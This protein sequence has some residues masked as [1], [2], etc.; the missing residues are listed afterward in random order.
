MFQLV[1]YQ[2]SMYCIFINFNSHYFFCFRC[3]NDD[4]IWILETYSVCFIFIP[5]KNTKD[6]IYINIKV[7]NEG[8]TNR[9]SEKQ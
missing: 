7:K 3:N 9:T 6:G 2:D 5:G 1:K 4:M 8:K